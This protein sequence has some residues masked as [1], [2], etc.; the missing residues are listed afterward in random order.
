MLGIVATVFEGVS[1][2]DK[3]LRTSAGVTTKSFCTLGD[4]GHA[5]VGSNR[6]AGNRLNGGGGYPPP[7]SPLP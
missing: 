7:P 5:R 4:G 1:S 3:P 6:G 2:R